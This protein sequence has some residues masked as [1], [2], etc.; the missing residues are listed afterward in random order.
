MKLGILAIGKA[1]DGP[2]K[3]LWEM[4][5]SR[6]P[7]RG[8]L[9]EFDTKL[10][11]GPQ[12]TKDESYKILSWFDEKALKGSRLVCLDPY[13]KDISS[14]SLAEC[15]VRWRDSGIPA[16]YFAIGGADGHHPDLLARAHQK[17]AFGSATW[18]HMLFRAML[19][20]QLYR[21]EMISTG[22]PY[23]RS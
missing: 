20:E 11:A 14:E 21:A 10:P 23:H 16:T 8:S 3:R 4:Y 13:G 19:A 22:H 5:L 15:V 18:P 17:L 9:V 7:H 1:K 6:L 2:E 12:R